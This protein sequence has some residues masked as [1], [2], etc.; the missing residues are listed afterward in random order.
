M[1]VKFCIILLNEWTWPQGHMFYVRLQIQWF[2]IPW[3]N[4]GKQRMDEENDLLSVVELEVL[5]QCSLCWTSP[6][7]LDKGE[8]LQLARA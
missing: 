8:H 3:H 2:L 6:T 5:E 7:L 4:V 1:P